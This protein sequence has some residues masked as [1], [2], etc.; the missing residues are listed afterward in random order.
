[1]H[2]VRCWFEVKNG[3]GKEG[4]RKTESQRVDTWRERFRKGGKEQ[5]ETGFEI[6]T[7]GA[8]GKME[9]MRVL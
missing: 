1:V 6:I 8:R 5:E 2:A 4:K 7:A 9:C 3:R